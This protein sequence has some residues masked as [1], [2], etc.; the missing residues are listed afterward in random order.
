M[1]IHYQADHDLEQH[2]LQYPRLREAQQVLAAHGIVP[3][4]HGYTTR[5]LTDELVRRGWRWDV[6]AERATA[7]KDY[8]PDRSQTETLVV[9]GDDQVATL[10]ITLAD[11][12]RFDDEHGLQTVLPYQADIEVLA[13]N[14][15]AIAQVE[16]KNP[17]GLSE[18]LA[19]RWRRNLQ[20]YG[21][22]EM[23]APYFMLVSQ[24][25]GYLWDQRPS[26]GFNTPPD[27]AFSMQDVVERYAKWLEPGERLSG[28]SMEIIVA[29]WLNDL[30]SDSA[31]STEPTRQMFEEST[32]LDDIRGARIRIDTDS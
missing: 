6:D 20:V 3:E 18:D 17:I 15:R 29:Q 32:F 5:Q 21:F 7:T 2:Y 28:T 11:A 8:L 9:S 14:G 12:I 16:V 22:A 1:S 26:P 24:D 13:P 30:A 19:R 27:L 10:A 4:P 31:T 23:N 25:F